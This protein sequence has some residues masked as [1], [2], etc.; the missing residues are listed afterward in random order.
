MEHRKSDRLCRFLSALVL[1]LLSAQAHAFSSLHQYSYSVA[2]SGTYE[3]VYYTGFKNQYN[4]NDA[5]TACQMG[6]NASGGCAFPLTTDATEVVLSMPELSPYAIATSFKMY[7]PAGTYAVNVAGYVPQ[8]TQYAYA[9]RFNAEP[10]RTSAL[11]S[12]EYSA[13]QTS[14]N[15]STSFTRLVNGEEILVAHDGG[16]TLR[17]VGGAPK[18]VTTTTG[19]W[20][21]FRQLQPST[22]PMHSISAVAYANRTTFV[23]AYNSMSWA[24]SGDP[25]STP[26]ASLSSVSAIPSEL[27]YGSG[28][29]ST[30]TPSPSNASL[31]TCTFSPASAPIAISGSTISLT[32]ATTAPSADIPV[33]ITCNGKTATLTVKASTQVSLASISLSATQLTYGTT[34]TATITASPSGASLGTCSFSPTTAPLSIS[35]S[36]ISLVSSSSP[37][38]SDTTV[39]ISCSGKTQTLTVK[40]AAQESLTSIALSGSEMTF[41]GSQTLTITPSP[42]SASLGTC[43]FSP[44]TAPIQVSG[45]TVSLVNTATGPTSDTTV[46]VTCTGKSASFTLKPAG[47]SVSETVT[48]SGLKLDI[49]LRPVTA[50]VG[51]QATIWLAAKLPSDGAL[52]QGALWF[53]NTGTG[54]VLQDVGNPAAMAFKTNETLATSGVYTLNTGLEKALMTQHGLEIHI[55]YQTTGGA[56][57]NIGKVWPAQ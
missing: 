31:G 55:G 57:K 45:S 40:P 42:A 54:W 22:T 6:M 53:F 19:G 2:K 34:Q 25:S 30:L 35:N 50:D 14:E 15:I 37:P 38:T 9:L 12:A 36:T 4:P 26:A 21:Y 18:V 11:S 33:T 7:L 46:S 8:N 44:T 17:F 28:L 23:S 39:T 1:T 43:T 56:F 49:T 41:G 52:F 48:S 27:T 10:A 47:T 5:L 20:L 29:T 3:K 24:V 51:K 13:A 32:S 16:G